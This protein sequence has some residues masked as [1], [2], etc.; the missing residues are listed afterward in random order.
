MRKKDIHHRARSSP[1]DGSPII[2]GVSNVILAIQQRAMIR[3][4]LEQDLSLMASQRKVDNK[5]IA[6]Y[7]VWRS[8]NCYAVRRCMQSIRK[9]PI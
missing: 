3:N 9:V 6:H 1:S 8:C 4:N 2:V 5:K 7:S